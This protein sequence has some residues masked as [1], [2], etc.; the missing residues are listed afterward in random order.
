[1]W[2]RICKA[3]SDTYGRNYNG[4]AYKFDF[5]SKIPAHIGGDGPV[6]FLEIGSYEGVSL[7]TVAYILRSA[8]RLGEIVSVDP[9][10]PDGYFETPPGQQRLWKNSTS[11]TMEGVLKLYAN[12]NL[13]V[14]LIRAS[15]NEALPSLL[16]KGRKFDIIFVDGM[17]E[18]LAPLI[19]IS[20]SLLLLRDN[21]I[22]CLD[23]VTWRDVKPLADLCEKHMTLAFRTKTQM[24]FKNKLA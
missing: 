16:A 14:E 6:N 24:A 17:H 21:G 15:S 11:E 20:L 8:G 9:Y 7:L 19:D 5:F 12:S 13:S 4:H 18:G 10:Y 2:E 23:D 22:L 1:M 3:L